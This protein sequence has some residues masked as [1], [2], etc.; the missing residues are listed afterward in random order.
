MKKFT[1]IF[2]LLFFFTNLNAEEQTKTCKG[3]CENEIYISE[4]PL[5]GFPEKIK[6][7]KKKYKS[8]TYKTALR[9]KESPCRP[10]GNY[11]SVIEK[12]IYESLFAI[13][14]CMPCPTDI[15]LEKSNKTGF[16]SIPMI[17]LFTIYKS[18]L[19]IGYVSR[20]WV[21]F[22][23][24]FSFGRTKGGVTKSEMKELTPSAK[25]FSK[26]LEQAK[27]E[28]VSEVLFM[29]ISKK[30]SAF[31][32]RV[33]DK[34]GDSNMPFF[35]FGT[36]SFKSPLKEWGQITKFSEVSYF[37]VENMNDMDL[38]YWLNDYIYNFQKVFFDEFKRDNNGNTNVNANNLYTL[39][40]SSTD[41]D[42]IDK[43]I[44]G[45]KKYNLQTRN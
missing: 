18:S 23:N 27:D 14:T 39:I 7:G 41:L 19:D 25:N 33:I 15:K 3:F 12:K 37:E 30:R 32:M 44:K 35:Y 10:F 29:S 40:P 16:C 38:W 11:F 34:N 13:N 24:E 6:I 42:L 2:F 5:L 9:V 8:L 26:S 21:E 45:I 28:I 22:F 43:K 17:Q 31:F 36:I 1:F 4:R 20:E